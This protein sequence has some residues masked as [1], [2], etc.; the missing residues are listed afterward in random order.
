MVRTWC[1]ISHSSIRNGISPS[2]TKLPQIVQRKCCESYPINMIIGNL[3]L[4]KNR[5]ND[6]ESNFI[7]PPHLNKRNHLSNLSFMKKTSL[8]L[9]LILGLVAAAMQPA[10]TQT[11]PLKSGTSTLISALGAVP[12]L[13][14]F[15][16]LLKTPGLDK[17][18][19]GVTKNPF[20][21]L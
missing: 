2:L 5:C 1:F 14:T 20:T 12:S 10:N 4:H 11:N 9:L 17:L 7:G 6:Y 19:A 16:N 3:N 18:L 13:S 8:R 15:T 21:L